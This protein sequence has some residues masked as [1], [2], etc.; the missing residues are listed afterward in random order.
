MVVLGK[1][2]QIK[3]KRGE[4]VVIVTNI[5][6]DACGQLIDCKIVEGQFIIEKDPE[7][8]RLSGEIICLRPDDTQW[9]MI[10]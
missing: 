3:H 10:K 4:G 9:E 6:E 1:K 5:C 8:I 7:K 2:Y